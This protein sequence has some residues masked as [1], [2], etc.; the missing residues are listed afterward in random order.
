MDAKK[1]LPRLIKAETEAEVEKI[2][3][4]SPLCSNPKN[5]LPYG[6]KENN[7]GTVQN[8]QSEAVAALV[9][10]IVNAM[11]AVL[12]LKCCEAGIEPTSRAA[13]KSIQ[14]AVRRFFGI[15]EGLLVNASR[16]DR[17]KL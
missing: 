12:I 1:L 17:G 4:N 14:D 7:A 3:E 13:P 5:W 2:I 11:D 9:E 16:N 6:N 10:K 15:R 8:Q